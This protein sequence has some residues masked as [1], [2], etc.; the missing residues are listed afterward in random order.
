MYYDT[1]GSISSR[2]GT[3]Y[4]YLLALKTLIDQDVQVINISQN[5]SRL[6]GF[7]ASHGNQNAIDYLTRQAELTEAGLLR[8]IAARKAAGKGDF[9]ICVAAG[10][11]NSTYYYKD[12]D[13]PYGY[14]EDATAGESIKYVFGWRGEIGNSLALYNNFLNLMSASEVKDRVIVV[15]S[16]GID[17]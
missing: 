11:S 3:A 7:A 1:N 12:E 8:I 6:V 4:S 17:Y 16:V 9:V 13:A 15:G 5:T 14:R 2:Y 10:N